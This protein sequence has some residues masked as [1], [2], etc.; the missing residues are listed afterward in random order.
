MLQCCF[1][2][3]WGLWNF[4]QLISWSFYNNLKQSLTSQLWD[5]RKL[6]FLLFVHDGPICWNILMMHSSPLITPK[7]EH[8][9]S[10][11]YRSS[12]IS[13][14]LQGMWEYQDC[15]GN[16]RENHHS[17]GQHIGNVKKDYNI[18]SPDK[19]WQKHLA[20]KKTFQCITT[21]EITSKILQV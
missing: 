6:V 8:Q 7:I 4:T 11:Q 2:V 15:H 5:I 10:T 19:I 9:S 12:D 13:S 18:C 20:W 17:W 21:F 1:A 3:F 16:T 14:G